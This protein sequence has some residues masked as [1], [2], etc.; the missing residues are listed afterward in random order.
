MESN[1]PLENEELL[2]ASSPF[3]REWV[4]PIKVTSI[5]TAYTHTYTPTC[6][7]REKG[8]QCFYLSQRF[9]PESLRKSYCFFHRKIMNHSC[10]KI[11]SALSLLKTWTVIPP[12]SASWGWE[13]ALCPI[14]CQVLS[15][16]E[17]RLGEVCWEPGLLVSL[18]T[19][20]TLPFKER[21]LYLKK[22]FWKSWIYT[23]LIYFPSGIL[24]LNSY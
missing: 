5:S 24:C 8:C 18:W 4:I 23:I 15:S 14:I 13:P 21:I 7:Q 16:W 17:K 19:Q 12:T 3:N 11:L 10:L 22:F 9:T 2:K 20:G 6:D 1:D